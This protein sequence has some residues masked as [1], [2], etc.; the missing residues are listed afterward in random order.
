MTLEE[1][2][3]RFTY[4]A[5]KGDTWRIMSGLK[6]RGYCEDYALTVLFH[7]VC[8]GSLLKFL[9]RLIFGNAKLLHCTTKNGEGHA[10]LKVGKNYIDNWTKKWVSKEDMEDLGHEFHS[11][12]YRW[13][14]VAFK[15]L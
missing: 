11:S 4:V 15:L 3:K 8:Q 6:L 12:H 13:Y 9:C 7:V 14:H 1:I 10:V 5:D 2:N